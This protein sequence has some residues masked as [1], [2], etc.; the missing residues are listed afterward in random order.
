[1]PSEGVLFLASTYG[2]EYLHGIGFLLSEQSPFLRL[3]LNEKN[4]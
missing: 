4:K 2:M 3:Y 1:M